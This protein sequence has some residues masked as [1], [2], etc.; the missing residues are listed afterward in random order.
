MEK[1]IRNI[2]DYSINMIEIMESLRSEKDY[3]NTL[4]ATKG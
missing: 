1:I 4:I 2:N 3:P